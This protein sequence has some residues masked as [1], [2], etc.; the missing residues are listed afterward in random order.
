MHESTKNKYLNN[1]ENPTYLMLRFAY[2]LKVDVEDFFDM[3]DHY[4]IIQITNLVI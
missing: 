1:S 3:Q 4:R 2:V